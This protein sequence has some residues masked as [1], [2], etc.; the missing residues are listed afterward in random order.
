MPLIISSISLPISAQEN[1]AV[2]EAVRLS[3][4]SSTEI[5]NS[6]VVK[7][8][9]DARKN[10]DIR[11]VYT[12]ALELS[13][14]EEKAAI[15]AKRN[16]V[17]Y[18]EKTSFEIVPTNKL[19]NRPVVVG[20]G[21]AGIFAGLILAKY[22]Y[23][24]IILERGAD[25]ETRV[26]DVE[27]FWKSSKLNTESNVQF[28]EGGAGTF[29]DGKLTTRISD[30]Y[31]DF[32]LKTFAD[33]GAPQEI[34]YKAKPHIGTDNLRKVVKTIREEIISLGGEVRFNTK[35][36]DIVI[37][38][39]KVVAVKTENET[40]ETSNVVL[41]IGHSA[42]DTFEMLLNKGVVIETKPFSIGVRAEHLQEDIN[43]GLYN[44]YYDDPRL[45]KGEYQ[46]SFRNVDRAVYTFCMC[47]G[48]TVVPSSSEENSVVTNGMSEY[49]RDGKNANSAVVVSVDGSDFG[50]NPL[51]AIAFQRKLERLAFKE[52]G[53]DYK[54]PAQTLDGLFFGK[55]Q[56]NISRVTPTYAIGTTPAD[57][58]EIFPPQISEMLKT[59]F[60]VFDRRIKGF[61]ANDTVITGV[62]TRTSSPVRI[63]RNDNYEAIGIKGL[64]PC[65]EGAGYAGGIVSAAVDGIRVAKAI[66]GG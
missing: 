52:G 30:E 61:G 41:A 38:N 20:F 19:S 55:K 21:P 34:L 66:I 27:G 64:Y 14:D 3:R 47:P 62:E 10:N 32:V 23:E 39:S 56:L 1:E 40:I 22:G 63:T 53:N 44:N 48:G 13:C 43:K 28:G 65:A 51:D 33:N 46:L 50:H 29:S 37:E 12:I 31:C 36:T 5:V 2:S 25:V 60:K 57:F 26:K 8:S 16:N 59:G 4:V 54:A 17:K 42:R 9:V 49:K 35:M 58:N 45:P 18:R 6:Y 11:F 15:R 24:P 7:K